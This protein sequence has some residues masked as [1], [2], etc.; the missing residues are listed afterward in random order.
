MKNRLGR[1]IRRLRIAAGMTQKQL[2]QQLGCTEVMISRYE[3][4]VSQVPIKRLRKIAREL[5]VPVRNF[6]EVSQP[7]T[8][9]NSFKQAF[10]FDIDD[11]LVDGR[12]FCGETIARVITKHFP[13]ADFD[14]IVKLH[15]E[16]R[17]RTIEDLYVDILKELNLKADVTEL[18]AEDHRIQIENISKMRIFDGVVDILEFL[19]SNDKKLYVCTNRSRDL[20]VEMLKAN[21]I[22]PYFDEI[23][24]CVDAGYKKPNPYCLVDLVKR[25]G[26]PAERFIYF[27]DS[28]IDSQFAQNAEIEHIIF[29][30]YLN[31][32][33]IF[34]KLVDMFL[35]KHMVA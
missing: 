14:A 10:V 1:K 13:K 11:T 30:Q 29:D 34:K 33:A 4:G 32:K 6:F 31:N 7:S 2:S 18:L 8:S 5:G 26:I 15:E 19:K 20:L 9:P 35:E 27:G 23:I 17:G 16:I 12:Q 24:S 28:E 21:K 25:S 22:L 3:L